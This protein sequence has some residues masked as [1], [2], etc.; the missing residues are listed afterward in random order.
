MQ[1]EIEP[2]LLFGEF[3]DPRAKQRRGAQRNRCARVLRG[4]AH[5]L[6]VARVL[7]QSG[8]IDNRQHDRYGLGYVLNRFAVPFDECRAPDRVTA[9]DFAQAVFD[10]GVVVWAAP[11]DRDRF[12]IKR[13]VRRARFR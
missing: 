3:D 13:H 8:Q 4:Q 6:C 2:V 12:V 9:Y 5:G 11:V 7:G 10:R 1:G